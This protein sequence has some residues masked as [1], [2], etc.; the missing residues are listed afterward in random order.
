MTDRELTELEEAVPELAVK[1]LNEA[2]ARARASGRPVVVLIGQELVRVGP[3]GRTVLK[4]L[5]PQ[6]N[7]GIGKKRATK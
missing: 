3:N 7:V 6:T 1:A 4:T 2:Q 5:P